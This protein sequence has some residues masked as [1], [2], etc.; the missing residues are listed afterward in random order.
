MFKLV[1]DLVLDSLAFFILSLILM[2]PLEILGGGYA[3]E[4]NAIFMESM[5]PRSIMALFVASAMSAAFIMFFFGKHESSRKINHFLYEHVVYKVTQFG[6]S[7][8]SAGVG[9]LAGLSLA[10]VANEE[11]QVALGVLFTAL[12]FVA[13]WAF[14]SAIN[15][16]AQ[17]GFGE[18]IGPIVTRLILVIAFVGA[19]TI[20]A[21]SHEPVKEC[22]CDQNANKQVHWTPYAALQLPVT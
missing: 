19:P 9:M 5:A 21:L 10:A 17:N 18:G 13:Y 11:Y 8:S 6:M 7:F 1:K 12:V 22:E 20:Y 14:F 3:R 2:T 4:V 15:F 16:S